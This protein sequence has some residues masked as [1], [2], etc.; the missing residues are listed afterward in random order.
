[1]NLSFQQPSTLSGRNGQVPSLNAV[2]LDVPP[3]PSHGQGRAGMRVGSVCLSCMRECLYMVLH[4]DD[5]RALASSL[6][7]LQR[8]HLLDIQEHSK[9][10]PF[11][12]LE[13]L[14]LRLHDPATDNLIEKH[15]LPQIHGFVEDF[16]NLLVCCRVSC[17]V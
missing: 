17:N 5:T 8:Q 15:L 11:A 14:P 13:V 12:N 7:V 9:F 10:C 16:W 4:I 6:Q 3:L 2:L 1:M